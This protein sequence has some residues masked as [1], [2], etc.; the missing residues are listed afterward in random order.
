MMADDRWDLSLIMFHHGKWMAKQSPIII[1][2][3]EYVPWSA[4]F[5]NDD[6][7]FWW[8]KCHISCH[9]WKRTNQVSWIY[10]WSVPLCPRVDG[11]HHCCT[12]PI[13]SLLSG[14]AIINH[15]T[16]FCCALLVCTSKVTPP[17]DNC[18]CGPWMIHLLV[19]QLVTVT[20]QCKNQRVTCSAK[21]CL[22]NVFF[23]NW[24]VANI[25]VEGLISQ[26]NTILLLSVG[27]ASIRN[28][29]PPRIARFDN[30]HHKSLCLLTTHPLGDLAIISHY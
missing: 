10:E 19:M 1:L 17:K 30:N 7:P 23:S 16:A 6:L 13:R 18:L 12:K 26:P 4:S 21:P 2:P 25:N 3:Y 29:Q 14:T 24:S 15:G 5:P 27:I 28:Q 11:G 8:T 20:L 22:K 9:V